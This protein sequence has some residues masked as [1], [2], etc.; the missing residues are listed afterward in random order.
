MTPEP[1]VA[2]P[3]PDETPLTAPF[4]AA[5]RERR[6][7]VQRCRG[8]ERYRWPPEVACY[9]C[10]ALG[11]DW[12]PVSGRAILYS[13]TIAHPPLLPYFQ[14]RSPWP[15]AVVELEEG[16][17]LVTNLV[18]LDSID[19]RIGMALTADFEEIAGGVMLVVFKPAS[20]ATI[21]LP[22]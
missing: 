13:W 12:A 7:V 17:R 20:G 1:V 8:C 18:G 10:G 6:L 19:Y 3:L 22:A 14:Q 9:Y 4:W 16:P 5:A 21:D 11:H 2:R 15:V